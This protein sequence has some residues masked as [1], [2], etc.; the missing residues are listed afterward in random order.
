MGEKLW[1]LKNFRGGGSNV[2]FISVGHEKIVSVLPDQKIRLETE[3]LQKFLK[4]KFVWSK[5]CENAVHLR[6]QD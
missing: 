4:I 1:L 5:K 6:L 2:H 3:N